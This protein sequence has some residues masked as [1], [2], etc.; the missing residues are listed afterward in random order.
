MPHSIKA[1]HDTKIAGLAR[2][3]NYAKLHGTRSG[4]GA[5]NHRLAELI[6]A[7]TWTTQTATC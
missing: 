3:A 1:S 6:K 5:T 7:A 2:R 4:I